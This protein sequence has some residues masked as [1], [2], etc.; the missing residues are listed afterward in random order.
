[1]QDTLP[2]DQLSELGEVIRLNDLKY[3]LGGSPQFILSYYEW[4]E[5]IDAVMRLEDLPLDG[6]NEYF[7]KCAGDKFGVDI[8]LLDL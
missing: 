5:K 7:M 2:M 4:M 1:M 3:R 6:N 8:T